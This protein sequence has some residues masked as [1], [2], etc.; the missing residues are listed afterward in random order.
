LRALSSP[1]PRFLS[2]D[3]GLCSFSDR[4]YLGHPWNSGQSGTTGRGS[5]RSGSQTK[6]QGSAGE[7]LVRGSRGAADVLSKSLHFLDQFE[8]RSSDSAC[9]ASL[10]TAALLAKQR[11]A[12][13]AR[14][15]SHDEFPAAVSLGG[16]A[17]RQQT[18]TSIEKFSAFLRK[19]S[20]WTNIQGPVT[21]DGTSQT[22]TNAVV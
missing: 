14:G 20:R 7:G 13:R 6:V 15:I 18:E 10:S 19:E 21:D 9:H 16:E 8:R 3:Q 17:L 2:S 12:N 1:S 11:F 5:V 22:G 4:R